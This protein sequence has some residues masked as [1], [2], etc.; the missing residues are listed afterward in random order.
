MC[1]NGVMSDE[2]SW[3]ER[4]A[5]GIALDRVCDTC[6]EVKLSKYRPEILTG[7]DQSD[8]DEPIDEE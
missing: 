4:D 3:W 2:E 7:Y 1:L 6:I 5:Q 8:V